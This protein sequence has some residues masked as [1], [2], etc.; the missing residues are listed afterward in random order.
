MTAAMEL[1]AKHRM[2]IGGQARDSASGQVIEIR[3]KFD[4][5]LIGTVPAGTVADAQDALD[6]AVDGAETCSATP[7]FRRAEILRA[8]AAQIRAERHD[9]YGYGYGPN[10]RR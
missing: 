10:Y 8:A 7:A 6:A 9:Q 5:H 3:D 1:L 2:S 4:G